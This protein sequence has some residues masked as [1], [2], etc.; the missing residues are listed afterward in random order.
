MRNYNPSV[1]VKGHLYHSISSLAHISIDDNMVINSGPNC[2]IIAGGYSRI[3]VKDGA[4]LKI[5][6]NFGM[7][8]TA[9]HCWEKIEIGNYVNI[10]ACCMIA[11]T[12]FHTITPP[13]LREDRKL[14]VKNAKTKPIKICDR[15]FIGACTI[16][17]KGVV[18]GENSVVQA[19]SVVVSNIPSNEIWGGAP[20]K[21]IKNID[22]SDIV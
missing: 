5:G 7:T 19:G 8:N 1:M 11:D 14:D 2:G 18:I 21:F 10:G 15:A 16:I 3:N 17:L 22:T 4:T 13:R 12:N 9:I 6:K 20:A